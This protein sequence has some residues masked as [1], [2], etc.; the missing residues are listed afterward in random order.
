MRGGGGG[1]DAHG[2]ENARVCVRKARFKAQ[3]SKSH[4]TMST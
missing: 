1:G 4:F 3:R 2:R